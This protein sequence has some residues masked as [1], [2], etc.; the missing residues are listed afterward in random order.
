MSIFVRLI[1]FSFSLPGFPIVV[2]FACG[3]QVDNVDNVDNVEQILV[4]G[5]AP[6]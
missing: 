3:G 5:T 6:S 2:V 1:A 4:F